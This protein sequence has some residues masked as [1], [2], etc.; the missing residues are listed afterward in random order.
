MRQVDERQALMDWMRDPVHAEK[1]GE[2]VGEMLDRLAG[3]I[4]SGVHLE[5]REAAPSGA[6]PSGAAPSGAALTRELTDRITSALAANGDESLRVYG[7]EG[8][9][10]VE[11]PFTGVWRYTTTIVEMPIHC[12]TCEGEGVFSSAWGR[13]VSNAR[14]ASPRHGPSREAVLFTCSD[15]TWWM[16]TVRDVCDAPVRMQVEVGGCT[17]WGVPVTD[18]TLA[19]LVWS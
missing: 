17:V 13:A 4:E 10:F 7:R 8:R 6:A 14:L 15:Q 3:I 18:D 11:V 9:V 2:R 16:W 12:L 5:G 19:T 1:G